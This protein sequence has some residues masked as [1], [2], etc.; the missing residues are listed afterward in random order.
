[1]KK[2]S[3]ELT[4]LC[5]SLDAALHSDSTDVETLFTLLGVGRDEFNRLKSQI[6]KAAFHIQ[7]ARKI[8]QF[9]TAL[10]SIRATLQ[11]HQQALE[12]ARTQVDQAGDP[13]ARA[14]LLN[15]I[16]RMESELVAL[17]QQEKRAEVE[18]A[19][20]ENSL[21]ALGKI[22]LMPLRI[23]LAVAMSANERDEASN[24]L[25]RVVNLIAWG[26]AAL[27]TKDQAYDA[28]RGSHPPLAAIEQFYK[29]GGFGGQSLRPAP[30]LFND[31]GLIANG[32]GLYQPIPGKVAAMLAEVRLAVANL[33]V[34]RAELEQRCQGVDNER[35]RALDAVYLDGLRAELVGVA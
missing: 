15:C 35:R 11:S 13:V 28:R 19:G 17:V 2:L 16:E 24:E 5:D 31:S 30:I 27:A 4:A 8:P 14:G 18:L 3:K 33:E 26:N 22:E 9:Q 23:K 10:A 6:S 7:L 12:Q 32:S 34:R 29:G 1:M 20:A 25:A 21:K